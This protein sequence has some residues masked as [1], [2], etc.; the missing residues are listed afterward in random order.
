[1]EAYENFNS[2]IWNF[3]NYILFYGF[4]SVLLMGY[5]KS[6]YNNKAETKKVR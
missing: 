3:N 6:F 4:Y 5:R 1:M 2:F